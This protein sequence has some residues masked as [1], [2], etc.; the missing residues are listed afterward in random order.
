MLKNDIIEKVGN[1]PTEWL[2]E[3][4]KVMKSGTENLR[5]CVDMKL[6]NKAIKREIYQMPSL[7]HIIVKANGMKL[8]TKLDLKSAFHQIELHP[9]S[10]EISKFR[11]TSS[12][13]QYKRLFFGINSA[14]E[15]FHNKLA[16]VLEGLKGTINANN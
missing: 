1:K 10:R 14:S 9:D 16:E 12:I 13:Y 15:I 6:A 2:N 4:V 3:T 7:E 11:T 5:I 8:F